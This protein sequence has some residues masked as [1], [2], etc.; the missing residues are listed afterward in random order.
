MKTMMMTGMMV[1]MTT[2]MMLMNLLRERLL[3]SCCV[4]LERWSTWSTTSSTFEHI[5]DNINGNDVAESEDGRLLLF[6]PTKYIIIVCP[7]QIY[8]KDYYCLAQPNI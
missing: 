2:M 8:E 4:S 6:V 3:C 7:N 5:D 1:V